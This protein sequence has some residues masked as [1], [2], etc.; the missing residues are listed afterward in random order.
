M[1]LPNIDLSDDTDSDNDDIPDIA[2]LLG[3]ITDQAPTIVI[4]SITK[5]AASDHF[6]KSFGTN[7]VYEETLTTTT[8]LEAGACPTAFTLK[9]ENDLMEF[10]ITSGIHPLNLANF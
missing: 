9:I 2:E 4:T 1:A 10:D 8:E 5:T 6:K 7:G 3:E